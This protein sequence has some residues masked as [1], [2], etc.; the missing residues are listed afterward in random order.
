MQMRTGTKHPTIGRGEAGFS[1]FEV[2][3]AA[4]VLAVGACAVTAAMIHGMAVGAT[5]SETQEAQEAA[6]RVLEQIS[7]VPVREVFSR[8]NQDPKDDPQGAGTAVG[9]VV[10]VTSA[11]GAALD[12]EI[13]FPNAGDTSVIREDVDDPEL[14]LP[15]DLNADSAIDDLDH[16]GDYVMLPVRVRVTWK[17]VTGTRSLDICSVLLD[18]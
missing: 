14:G 13:I 18:R 11:S 12:A 15:R 8:Y 5:N 1:L 3:V 10:T 6:R 2:L 4:A 17:G 9:N 7:A 16:S